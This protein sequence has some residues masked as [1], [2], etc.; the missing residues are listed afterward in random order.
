MKRQR[1]AT[2]YAVIACAVF[3]I[4]THIGDFM[5]LAGLRR[6]L[7][8]W[9]WVG[10]ANLFQLMICVSAIVTDTRGNAGKGVGRTRVASS[11]RTR[12][13]V[14]LRSRIPYAPGICRHL[15]D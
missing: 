11:N 9:I 15:F 13:G 2:W 12:R 6:I 3:V 8:G 14:F 7:Q 10:V 1:S 4:C 5:R